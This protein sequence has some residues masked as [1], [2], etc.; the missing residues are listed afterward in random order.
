MNLD[1]LTVIT[2]NGNPFTGVESAHM[3]YLVAK[4]FGFD[5]DAAAAAWRRMLENSCPTHQFEELV[6]AHRV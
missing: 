2:T 4:R 1:N 3:A 6:R 5:Y